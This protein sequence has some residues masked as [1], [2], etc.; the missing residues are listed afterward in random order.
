[1]HLQEHCDNGCFLCFVVYATNGTGP[2]LARLDHT[3]HC[4]RS[5]YFSISAAIHK[6]SQDNIPGVLQHLKHGML[7]VQ[8]TCKVYQTYTRSHASYWF[9]EV[10]FQCRYTAILSFEWPKSMLQTSLFNKI[11]RVDFW[12][13]IKVYLKNGI[14]HESEVNPEGMG[15]IGTIVRPQSLCQHFSACSLPYITD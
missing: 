10:G 7:H 4:V 1:M 9:V 11:T 13:R 2:F 8:V 12:P 5:S 3:V 6:Q 14:M 15:A